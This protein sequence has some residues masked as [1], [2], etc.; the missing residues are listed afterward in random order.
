MD[1]KGVKPKVNVDE[2]R[3]CA[4]RLLSRARARRAIV[5]LC[6][7]RVSRQLEEESPRIW[8]IVYFLFYLSLF[9][10][11]LNLFWANIDIY[12]RA[13]EQAGYLL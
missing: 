13:I 11:V 6:I 8:T 4:A 10:N 5:R 3:D 2:R 12:I 1:C 7:F 9:F